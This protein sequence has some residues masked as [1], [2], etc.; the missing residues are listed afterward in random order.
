MN[1]EEK[2]KKGLAGPVQFR[3][4]LKEAKQRW[5]VAQVEHE[6]IE[7]TLLDL[8]GTQYEMAHLMDGQIWARLIFKKREDK[9]EATNGKRD[10]KVL[11]A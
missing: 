11:Q 3:A 8:E 10:S 6:Y 1:L 4:K 5:I 7:Q 2:F 9:K